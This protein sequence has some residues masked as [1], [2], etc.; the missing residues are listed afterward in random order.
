MGLLW[1]AG[2]LAHRPDSNARQIHDPAGCGVRLGERWDQSAWLT[3]GLSIEFERALRGPV[4]S[5]NRVANDAGLEPRTH[6]EELLLC[7]G[8]YIP[9]PREHP[10]ERTW[11]PE[12][13]TA[14]ILLGDILS[15]DCPKPR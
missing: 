12:G 8:I 1:L 7:I 9:Q 14:M 15:N 5:L 13:P 6:A 3:E 11:R 4:S 2:G 10:E